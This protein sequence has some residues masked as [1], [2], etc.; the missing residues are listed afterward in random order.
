MVLAVRRQE[1]TNPVLPQ[2]VT[3]DI[4]ILRQ[5]VEAKQGEERLTPYRG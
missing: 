4:E 1:E 2:Y 3:R 5:S